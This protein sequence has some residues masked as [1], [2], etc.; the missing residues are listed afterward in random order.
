M[1]PYSG[2]VLV[3]TNVIAECHRTNSGSD[4][5]EIQPRIEG[6]LD[7]LLDACDL[8]HVEHV[9]AKEGPVHGGAPECRDHPPRRGPDGSG[10]GRTQVEPS[11]EGDVLPARSV[12]HLAVDT[13]LQ[14]CFLATIALGV[15]FRG[16]GL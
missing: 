3:D 16:E 4:L 13:A 8:E 12:L 2:P 11:M 5:P 15:P 14:I 1:P 7:R 9:F 10:D 6:D